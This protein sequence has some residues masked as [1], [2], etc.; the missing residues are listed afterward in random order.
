[1]YDIIAETGVNLK[2]KTF[3]K[4]RRAAIYG[5][6]TISPAASLKQNHEQRDYIESSGLFPM[7]Q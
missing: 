7:V 5:L 2:P 4:E 3:K 1:L 6:R